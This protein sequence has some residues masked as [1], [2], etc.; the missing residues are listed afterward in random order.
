MDYND[1][2]DL[3][4]LDFE[5]EQV[6]ARGPPVFNR[7]V[8]PTLVLSDTEFVQHFRFEKRTV[9][10]ISE[11]LHNDLHFAKRTGRPLSPIQQVCVA[12][13]TY[14][15]NNFQRISGLCGGVSG[16]GARNAIRRVTTGLCNQKE[17]FIHMPTTAQME[18]TSAR[19]FRKYK[20]PNFAFAVDGCH[21]RLEDAPRGLPPGKNQQAFW[22][23][24]QFYSIN[25]QVVANDEGLIYDL[26]VSWPGSTHD[27]RVWNRSEVKAFLGQQRRF[28]IAG[29]SA[30]P[31]SEILVKPYAVAE[32]ANDRSMRKFNGRLS[33]LRTAMSENVYGI[34]KRRFP[35]IRALRCHLPFSQDIIVA[36]AVLHNLGIL[37]RDAAVFEEE[38]EDDEDDG[39]ADE[40]FVVEA[41]RGAAAILAQ[42]KVHRDRLRLAMP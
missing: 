4:A 12:L 21:M 17:T 27:A 11:L 26:D 31:M 14:A 19:M 6:P 40:E 13:N 37:W 29:D 25:T 18:A 8:D 32:A 28:N 1:F 2:F 15:G 30:Y 36:T 35:I 42:G 3:E 16:T 10:D 34:W 7:R 38:E 33:G 24:K 22:C 5:D 20:L 41:P 23:R 39:R 9:R